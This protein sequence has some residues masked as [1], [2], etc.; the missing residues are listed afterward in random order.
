MTEWVR[1]R[2][3]RLYLSFVILYASDIFY[4]KMGVIIALSLRAVRRIK[5]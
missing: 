2:L 3:G 5:E 1:A 4:V